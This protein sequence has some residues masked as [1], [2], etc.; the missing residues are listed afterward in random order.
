MHSHTESDLRSTPTMLSPGIDDE[1]I[2]DLKSRTEFDVGEFIFRPTQYNLVD[3][4][5]DDV[6]FQH[7]CNQYL[8]DIRKKSGKFAGLFRLRHTAPTIREC[9]LIGYLHVGIYYRSYC[10]GYILYNP[11]AARDILEPVM[12][13]DTVC[14]DKTIWTPIIFEAALKKTISVLQNEYPHVQIFQIEDW[15]MAADAAA[16]YIRCGFRPITMRFAMAVGGIS[17]EKSQTEELSVSDTID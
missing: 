8:E 2:A 16:I 1:I 6:A 17:T 12:I 14:L 10:I 7:V 13:I 5:E 11:H 15:V 9:A 4:T 3:T